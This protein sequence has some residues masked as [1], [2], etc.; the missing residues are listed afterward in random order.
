MKERVLAAETFR[1]FAIFA[2]I[3]LLSFGLAQCFD[4]NSN[5]ANSDAAREVAR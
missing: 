1:L 4:R 5:A 3:A 2:V